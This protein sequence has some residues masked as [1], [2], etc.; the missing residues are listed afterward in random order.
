[1][2]GFKVLWT[3][4]SAKYPENIQTVHRLSLA[5]PVTRYITTNHLALCVPRSH[6]ADLL[7]W[8]CHQPPFVLS[9]GGEH[10]PYVV[11]SQG[12]SSVIKWLP[13]ICVSVV[14]FVQVTARQDLFRSNQD[15]VYFCCTATHCLTAVPLNPQSKSRAWAKGL[16]SWVNQTGGDSDCGFPCGLSAFGP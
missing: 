10:L 9:N 13:G 2:N 11:L 7:L 5:L 4:A 12:E 8:V 14:G 3:K 15:F 16:R 1:M 6:F